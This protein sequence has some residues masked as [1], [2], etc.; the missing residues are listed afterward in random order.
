MNPMNRLKKTGISLLCLL[1]VL[2]CLVGCSSLGKPMMTLGDSE[3]TVNMISLLLSRLKGSLTLSASGSIDWDTIVDNEKGTTYNDFYTAQGIHAAK[4]YL[5]ALYLF[6]ERGL[7]LADSEVDRI[8]AEIDQMI[9]DAGSKAALNEELAQYGA[10]IKILREVYLMEAKMEMLIDDL[11]GADG[12]KID[13]TLKDQY[14]TE[15]YRRYKQIF[16]PL[17]EFVY[18]TDADGEEVK[19]LDEDGN[20]VIRALTEE[21]EEALEDLQNEILAQAEAGDFDGFDQLVSGYDEEPNESSK[22]YPNGFYLTEN[23]G[24]VAE[25]ADAL[26]EMEVG[27]IRTVIPQDGYGVYIIMR[28]EAETDGYASEDNKAFFGTF[29]E[30]LKDDLIDEYLE[31]Y[32]ADIVVDEEVALG[33]DMKSIGANVYY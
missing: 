5:A 4:T 14:Y 21:E 8:D 32:E 19:K 11:Y 7:K 18:E 20:Y 10:N 15:N 33:V 2:S 29:T 1:L 30:E 16:L 26:F 3:L 25:V 13:K 17:Y 28:Y 24:N 9:Q 23:G 27:E 12:E 31:R 6:E 22:T